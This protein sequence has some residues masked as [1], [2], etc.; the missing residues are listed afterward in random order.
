MKPSK[1]E[2]DLK[3]INTHSPSPQELGNTNIRKLLSLG[4]VRRVSN[5]KINYHK[6][7]DAPKWAAK[8]KF[9]RKKYGVTESA[10]TNEQYVLTSKGKR[11]LRSLKKLKPK[12]KNKNQK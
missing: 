9:T 8:Y 6:P 12:D 10:D 3:F 2:R 11:K 1:L 7:K 4:L 5:T